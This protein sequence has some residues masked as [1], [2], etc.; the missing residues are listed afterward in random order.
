M[1]VVNHQ[2]IGSAH[3]SASFRERLGRV[4][5][6]SGRTFVIDTRR[7]HEAYVPAVHK[8]NE[9]EVMR[10]C[11]CPVGPQE[12]VSLDALERAARELQ[13]R[14]QSPLV[15]TRGER[16]CLVCD[17]GLARQLFGVRL[18]GQTDPVGAGDTFVAALAGLAATGSELGAAAFVG[19]LAGAVTARKLFQTG[20]ASPAEILSL[21][22][23]ADFILHPELAETPGLARLF[24]ESEI[25]IVTEDR[26]AADTRHAVFDHDGTLSTLRHGWEN[27]MQPM[28]V[29]AVLGNR[30]ETVPGAVRERV[31]ADVREDI[32]QSTGIQTLAQMKGLVALVRRYGFVPDPDLLDEH[33]YKALYNEELMKLVRTRTRKIERGELSVLDFQVKGARDFLELLHRAGVK[34]YLVSGTDEADARAEAELLGYAH[35]FTGGIHGAVGDLRVE[36]KRIVLERLVGSLAHRGQDLLVVGDGPVEMREGHR[37]GALCLGVASHEISLH[38]LNPTKRSRLIR[39][40]ADLIV[41]DYSQLKNL[42][43]LLGLQAVAS[44]EIGTFLPEAEPLVGQEAAGQLNSPR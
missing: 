41:P 15:I 4:V 12:A 27:I 24:E 14:W 29:R 6:E 23:E 31:E 39:A 18:E 38:G 30:P 11:G 42:R 43:R 32:D 10:A 7:Y 28:M 21:A 2:V 34:L 44:P 26:P 35:L 16:G 25:E 22:S 1:V 33:G 40:G 3:E 13:A 5:R 17:K 20:T 8:L 36:A 37:R 9:R 19:N